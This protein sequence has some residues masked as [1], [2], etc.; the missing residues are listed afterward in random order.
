MG[1]LHKEAM[2]K[3]FSEFNEL[4][5]IY[6]FQIPVLT[7]VCSDGA[8]A[9]LRIVICRGSTIGLAGCW[10]WLIFVAIFGMGAENRSGKREFQLRAGAGFC[11]FKGS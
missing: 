2:K 7:A 5:D 6:I 1:R 8:F 4:I 3:F 11:V 9:R 10:I